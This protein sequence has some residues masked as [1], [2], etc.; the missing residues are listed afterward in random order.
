MSATFIVV[1]EAQVDFTTATGLADRVLTEEIDWLDD[2]LL[3]ST[4]TVDR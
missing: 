2:T 1:Y 4:A 3:D